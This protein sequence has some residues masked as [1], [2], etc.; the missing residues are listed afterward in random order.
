MMR[1]I[2]YYHIRVSFLGNQKDVDAMSYSE[3]F[4]EATIH[5]PRVESRVRPSYAPTIHNIDGSSSG[6]RLSATC[7]A[8]NCKQA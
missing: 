4:L 2:I 1:I 5:N 6:A 3:S 7:H 8:T